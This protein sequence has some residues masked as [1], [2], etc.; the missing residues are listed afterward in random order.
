MV[1]ST[2]VSKSTKSK[3]TPS[4]AAKT[5]SPAL[6]AAI[7]SAT[8]AAP[9]PTVVGNSSPEVAS[10]DLKMKTLVDMA[11]ERSGVKKKDAKPAIEAALAI[12][13]EAIAD[14]RDLNLPPLGKL[15]INRVKQIANGR[16]VICKLRQNTN[17]SV[18]PSDDS[19]A[20]VVDA[21]E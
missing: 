15:K 11:V 2:T 1:K 14:G 12:L 20:P 3:S 21:A 6:A 8:A 7:E 13:G 19:A 17:T 10:L 18:K 5:A 16:V 9:T 4:T